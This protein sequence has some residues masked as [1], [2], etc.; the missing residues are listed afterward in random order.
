MRRIN[1]KINLPI[2]SKIVSILLPPTSTR[3]D[4]FG[5]GNCWLISRHPQMLEAGQELE[6][7]FRKVDRP[8]SLRLRLL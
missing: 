4:W 2:N 7:L 5:D 1:A 8:L 6:L 3:S